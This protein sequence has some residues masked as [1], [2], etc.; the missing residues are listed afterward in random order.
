[1]LAAMLPAVPVQATPPTGFADLLV[2]GDGLDSPTALEIAPDGRIFVLERSGAIRIVKNGHLLAE[3]FAVLP[4]ATTGDRGLLGVAFDPDFGVTNHYAYFYYTGLDLLNHVVRF[5]AST[6][7]GADGPRPIFSTLVPSQMY[8]VGGTIAFGPD[9]KLYLGIGDNGMPA[10]AQDLSNPYGKI[11]RLN[12][13]GSVPADNPFVGQPGA[14]GAIW[15]YGLRNPFRF[16]F[17]PAS[18]RLYA[19]DVGDAHW[20]ELNGIV[21]GAN[22]G[23]PRAEGFCTANCAGLTDPLYPYPHVGSSSVV[24]GPVY[25]GTLFP[26][27][28]RNALFFADYARGFIKVAHLAADGSVT[29]VSSFDETAGTVVDLKVAP[30]GSLYYVDIFPGSLHRIVY[31]TTSRA[32]IARA[33]AS[34]TE[35]GAPL[36]VSFSSAGSTD[37]DGD[38]L[39][40]RWDFG[41]GTTSTAANPTRTFTARGTYTVRL[42]VS[43]GTHTVNA[44]PLVVTVGVRPTVT[45]TAPAGGSTYRAGDTIHYGVSAVDAAGR[46]LGDDAVSTTVVFHHGTHVHPF[47]GPVPGRSGSFVI[48][49]TGEP[50]ADTWYEIV[51]TATD[52]DGVT[53]TRSVGIHPVITTLSLTTD[54]PGGQLLLDGVPT[55]AP[56]SA[57]AVVGYQRE[58]AA[59]PTVVGSDG[60]TYHFTGWSDGG[61]IR[62]TITVADGGTALTAHYARSAPFVGQYFA[63]RD[64][65]GQPVLTR[66]DATIDFLW[67]LAAPAPGVPADN[68]SVRWSRSEY[69][70]AATYRFTTVSDDGVRLLVD[71]TVIIDAWRDMSATVHSALVELD[72][73]E[74]TI[75][76]EYFDSG[77]DAVVSLTWDTT[78]EKPAPAQQWLAEYWNVPDWPAAG[79]PVVPS[80]AADVSRVEGAVDYEWWQAA[81]VAG[82]NADHF[83]ARWTRSLSVGSPGTYE[84]TVTAD[85]GVRLLVDG[86]VVLDRWVDQSAS[87][88]VVS[89]PLSVG[90]HTVVL[91]YYENAWDAT[92]K[93]SV[94]HVH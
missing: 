29:S 45:I 1:L 24:G 78:T 80:R 90:D 38:P 85:D 36:T 21:A 52:A 47:L 70:A 66:N 32:P 23:W 55:A 83:V 64:L 92:A 94:S 33:A 73:G 58:V 43:D 57:P 20:E 91:E 7:V 63:N 8:H 77:W 60:R 3:P 4:S 69:L 71:G 44:E 27:A 72:A 53:A 81:P 11:L 12:P 82:I 5:D 41:D 9:G 46:V 16:Q 68:F 40:F 89:V 54:V 67:N 88:F 30:D 62:H 50:A 6:D 61:A 25:H 74:H 48:P 76:L 84:F 15:A 10:N 19:G 65:A 75:V 22:Y 13:D 86:V 28:Y 35:G 56:Y 34:T 14:F 87:T 59:P 26:A 37:P 17:D 51:V 79:A 2:V 93:V 18:G 31:E 39:S 42:A 49:T